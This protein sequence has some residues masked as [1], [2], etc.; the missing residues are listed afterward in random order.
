MKRE[1]RVS[2]LALMHYM[3]DSGQTAK[4]VLLTL[5]YAQLPKGCVVI[6]ATT[7]HNELQMY[8]K[9]EFTY[10]EGAPDGEKSED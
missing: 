4:D 1:I 9:V 5:M 3:E 8:T 6:E 2:D 10:K 7:T